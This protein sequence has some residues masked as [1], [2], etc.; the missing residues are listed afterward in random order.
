[1]S[2]FHFTV[3]VCGSLHI[4][5]N[6]TG[7]TERER[8][9]ERRGMSLHVCT[10]VRAH[11]LFMCWEERCARVCVCVCTCVCVC[12]HIFILTMGVC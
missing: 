7:E 5:L 2:V 11:I 4:R 1:M 3:F 10:H 12:V 6:Y 9:R 8:K